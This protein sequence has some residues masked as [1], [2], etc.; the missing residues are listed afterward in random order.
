MTDPSD[1]IIASTDEK[2]A[3][4]GRGC[5]DLVLKLENFL[6][7]RV[8]VLSNTVSRAIA[9]AYSLQFGLSIPEWRVLAV[10]G[11]FPDISAKQV[12][13]LTAMDK[14]RVCRAVAALIAKDHLERRTHRRDRRY[15]LLRHSA[16]GHA[17]YERIVP[18]ALS[19]ER[20]LLDALTTGER[21]SLDGLLGKLQGVAETL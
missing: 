13:E 18:L 17:I 6:P 15:S 7:Y 21:R 9:S 2:V 16:K 5:S 4:A 8:S 19:Y 11:R 14:V 10:L 20:V 1:E 3:S 12:A